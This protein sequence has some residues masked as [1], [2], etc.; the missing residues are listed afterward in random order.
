MADLLSA[1]NRKELLRNK[2]EEDLGNLCKEEEICLIGEI[3]N[4]RKI[5]KRKKKTFRAI[6]EQME[7]YFSDS[8]LQKDKF[9]KNLIYNNDDN[10]VELRLFLTFNKIKNLTHDIKDIIIALEKSE[11]LELNEAGTHVRRVSLVTEEKDFDRCTI[12]V[13]RLPPHT[14]HDWLKSVFSNFGTVTY[15][16]LPKFKSTGKPKGFAFVEFENTEAAQRACENFGSFDSEMCSTDVEEPIEVKKTQVKEETAPNKENQQKRKL[17]TDG[18]DSETQEKRQKLDSKAEGKDCDPGSD[19][20]V[21]QKNTEESKDLP[22]KGHSEK[23]SKKHKKKRRRQRKPWAH[24]EEVETIGLR[25]MSKLEW[26]RWRNKYL[27]L[28]KA[29]MAQVKKALQLEKD[30]NSGRKLAWHNNEAEPITEKVTIDKD[31]KM[32]M[33]PGV[34]V[35]VSREEQIPRPSE[36]KQKIQSLSNVAYVDMENDL[37]VY[38][39]CMDPESAKHLLIAGKEA[40]LGKL[41]ILEGEEEQN[42]W[43]KINKD[44][45][46]RLAMKPREKKRGMSK[47]IARAEKAVQMKNKHIRFDD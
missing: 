16:S 44:R 6:K 14:D 11:L 36:F 26:K 4:D 17:D 24:Q 1:D 9:L 2:D 46:A 42:Y 27:S 12:Y 3:N 41:C 28:Q 13:E 8:N 5:R 20:L 32:E 7:F 47:V 29:T 10:Y 15:V 23:L 38:I 19:N 25:V 33:T 35:K 18:S 30:F 37:T 39:R 31:F 43:E 45:E 40:K 22:V 21:S 34:I